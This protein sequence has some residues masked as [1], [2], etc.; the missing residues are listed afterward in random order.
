MKNWRKKLSYLF[1][2]HVETTSSEYHEAL[3]VSYS[4]G[5][6]QLSTENA[7]YS[8]G[9][10]YTNYFRAFEEIDLDKRKVEKVLILGFGLGSIPMMLEQHFD[11]KYQYTA[12]EIDE[13]ILYLAHKYVTHE[14]T[15]AIETI[16]TDAA[17]FVQQ[18]NEVFDI[19]CVDLFLDDIIPDTF[20]KQDFLQNVKNLIAPEGI[21]LYNRLA[22]T[23]EDKAKNKAFMK[24]EFLP[25]FPEGRYLDVDGNWMFVNE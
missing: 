15:S 11:K 16:C 21:L 8:F 20:Q 19:I 10:L 23:N 9:D 4:R 22:L 18:C 24:N 6:Y 25:V 13:E 1:E 2:H 14:L 5:R 12:V 3:H 7:I 17:F